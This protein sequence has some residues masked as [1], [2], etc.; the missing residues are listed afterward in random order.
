MSEQSHNPLNSLD[1]DEVGQIYEA[2][3]QNSPCAPWLDLA[4]FLLPEGMTCEWWNVL[5]FQVFNI[6]TNVR[7]ASGHVQDEVLLHMGA[8]TD[9]WNRISFGQGPPVTMYNIP[10]VRSI[11]NLRD[12]PFGEL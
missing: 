6:I 3:T 5:C 9:L 12:S 10:E 1:L 8:G 4:G 2:V 7:R 11:I